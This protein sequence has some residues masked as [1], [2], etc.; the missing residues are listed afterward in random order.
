M[1][2]WQSESADTLRR[3]QISFMPKH[4]SSND[5][6]TVQMLIKISIKINPEFSFLTDFKHWLLKIMIIYLNTIYLLFKTYTDKLATILQDWAASSLSLQNTKRNQMPPVFQ[7]SAAAV[8]LTHEGLG[9]N[10]FIKD[11]SPGPW[12]SS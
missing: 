2:M 7:W 9:S 11:V 12:Q 1:Q 3:N 6:V 4:C 5:I 10:C 8:R